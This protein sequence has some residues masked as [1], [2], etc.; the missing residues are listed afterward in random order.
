MFGS[1]SGYD[2]PDTGATG[3][4][5]VI[6]FEFKYMSRLC[7]RPVD[8]NK[9][10]RV[11]IFGEELGQQRGDGRIVLRRFEGASATSGHGANERKKTYN[12]G[13]VPRAGPETRHSRHDE[14]LHTCL[15][16]QC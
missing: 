4:E 15:L 8:N 12:K 10:I 3:E 16:T 11:K 13:V 6:P 5:D 2:P 1:G 14:Q 9:C 7:L